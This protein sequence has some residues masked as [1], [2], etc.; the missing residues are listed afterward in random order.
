MGVLS[1]LRSFLAGAFRRPRGRRVPAREAAWIVTMTDE[2]IR[3]A[4]PRGEVRSIAR[5]RIAAVLIETNDSGPWG[6]DFWW[7]LLGPD[8]SLACA[9][10]QGATGESE[11]ME[12]LMALPGFDHG[13]MIEAS[14]ST[15][16]ALFP[17][18]ER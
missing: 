9:F 17:V 7:L 15:G 2:E 11:A 4:D 6:S 16:N 3:V 14:V 12:W 18:W 8:K 10:P 5:E 13:R 1:S